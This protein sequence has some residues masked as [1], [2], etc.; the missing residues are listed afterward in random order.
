MSSKRKYRSGFE[1]KIGGPLEAAGFSYEPYKITY[2]MPGNYT[3]DFVYEWVAVEAKGWFRPG[4]QKKYLQIRDAIMTDHGQ[5][6]VFLLQHP[7]KKVRKGAKMTM[8]D[9]C[10]KHEI[11]W[12][13]TPEEVIAYAHGR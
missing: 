6:L 8:A 4:D 2:W 11:A 13:A 3:P 10:D 12:F 5:E 7:N 9:W 1:E